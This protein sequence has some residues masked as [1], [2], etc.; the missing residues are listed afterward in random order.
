MQSL[1]LLELLEPL[2]AGPLPERRREVLADLGVAVG[3]VLEGF[4]V[5]AADDVAEVL[6]EVRLLRAERDPAAVRGLVDVVV[7]VRAGEAAGAGA[8][9]LASRQ[10]IGDGRGEQVEHAVG[11]R[12]VDVLASADPVAGEQRRADREGGHRPA[13]GEV[14]EDV[15]RDRRLLPRPPDRSQRPG[16]RDVVD[17]VPHHQPVGAVLPVARERAVDDTRVDA[18]D[19]LVV[20]AEPLHHARPEALEDHVRVLAEA[21]EDLLARVLAEVDHDRALVA[22]QRVV[23]QIPLLGLLVDLHRLR[24]RAARDELRRGLDEQHV[25]AEVTEQHAAERSRRQP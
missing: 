24:R 8:R 14:R 11:H 5:L 15:E 22:P 3:L 25:R 7:R 10:Q 4:E 9:R 19:R 21:V 6:P 13:A 17:V 18:R 12:E 1:G 20:D 23:A 2:V 16:D